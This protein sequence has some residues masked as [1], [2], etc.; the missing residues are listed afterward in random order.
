MFSS[1]ATDHL[2][3]LQLSILRL[4]GTKHRLW[5]SIDRDGT[6]PV[7]DFVTIGIRETHQF[8]DLIRRLTG[9]H[10]L[11]H[12]QSISKLRAPGPHREHDG[13]FRGAIGVDADGATRRGKPRC[14]KVVRMAAT[15]TSGRIQES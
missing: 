1:A 10:V 13:V 6:V 11:A 4:Y 5:V 9:E 14:D 3:S 15:I 2:Q 12:G 7:D 8:R